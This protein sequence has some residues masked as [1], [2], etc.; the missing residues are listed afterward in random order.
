MDEWM[1]EWMNGWMNE[2][3]DEWTDGWAHSIYNKC[4]YVHRQEKAKVLLQ[5][6]KAIE[7]ILHSIHNNR[8]VYIIVYVCMYVS[9]II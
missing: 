7:Q 6:M 3:T 5:V 4:L 8:Y 1:D 2:W 9:I